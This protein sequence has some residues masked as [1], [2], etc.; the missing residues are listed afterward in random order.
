MAATV[1]GPPDRRAVRRDA[2]R[3]R[4]LE[5]AWQLARRDG[6]AAISMRDLAD[7]VGLRQPSLYTY[8]AS[9]LAM[10]DAMFAEANRALLAAFADVPTTGDARQRFAALARAFVQFSTEDPVRHQL[11]FQRTIPGFEPSPESYAVARE[12]YERG[13]AFL[14]AAGGTASADMDVWTALVAGLADQQVSNDP[15]GDR[16]VRLVDRVVEMFLAD[17]DRRR[18]GAGP[19]RK[20]R[21]VR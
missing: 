6:L 11:L 9:K 15:G 12:V 1:P 19:E 21:A 2:Q 17:L 10:Y 14:A 13:R 4:I 18:T 8:F 3:A 20:R 16:W 7:R 5:Q